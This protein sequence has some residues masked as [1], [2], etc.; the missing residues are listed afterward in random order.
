MEFKKKLLFI[1]GYYSDKVEYNGV[2]KKI[3]LEISTFRELGFEVDYVEFIDNN[4]YLCTNFKKIL[5]VEQDQRFFKTM[6]AL[7]KFLNKNL[8]LTESYDFVYVRYEHVSFSMLRFFRLLKKNKDVKIVG[9]LPTYL[10]IWS[11]NTSFKNKI[12]FVIKRIIDLS[13]PKKI[14]YMATFSDHTSIF[15]VPTVNIENFVDVKNIPLRLSKGNGD[16]IHL[17]A[18]AQIS[19]AHGF[20]KVISGLSDFY[21]DKNHSEVKVFLHVVG[22]GETKKELEEMTIQLK[23]QDYVVFYGAKGGKELDEIFNKC[24][25]GIAALAIFRKG[26]YKASELKLREY[27]ARGLPFIYNAFEPQIE[28]VDFCLKIPFDDSPVDIEKVIEFHKYCKENVDVNK[29]RLFAEEK[30]TCKPQ[31]QKILDK[32]NS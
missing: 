11:P 1:S 2:A 12:S 10:K 9:E 7:Y 13:T 3:N 31:L 22:D 23:L 24:D 28:G 6:D 5:L 19:P 21:K 18:L 27:T 15:N 26:V 16:S 25:I 30:F 32:L 17:L 20:D 8:S 4:V 29:M 14:D